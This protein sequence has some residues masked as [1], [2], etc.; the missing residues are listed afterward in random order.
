MASLRIAVCACA[1]ASM[2]R[3]KGHRIIP[4][5]DHVVIDVTDTGSGIP[6]EIAGK[7]FEPFFTTKP[8]GQGTGLGLSTVYGIVKQTG[9]YIFATR[10]PGGIGTKFSVFLPA[11]PHG[12]RPP[13]MPAAPVATSLHA[14]SLAGVRV[15]ARRG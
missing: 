3:R 7:I 12:E 1:G 13:D 6:P 8:M 4:R 2:S 9:G 14:N 15:A 5:V 10:A 11:V